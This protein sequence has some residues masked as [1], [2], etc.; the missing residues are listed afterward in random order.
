M[1]SPL[2][3]VTALPEM[4]LSSRAVMQVLRA[5]EVAHMLL[6]PAS[7]LPRPLRADLIAHAS[8]SH[9]KPASGGNIMR[10]RYLALAM[11]WA[12]LA[13][14]LVSRAHASDEQDCNAVTV[15]SLHHCVQHAFEMGHISNAGVA[16]SLLRK[17]D[18]AIAAEDL[19]NTSLAARILEAFINEVEAQAGIHIDS[20]HADHM[21][22]HATNVIV[23][24]LSPP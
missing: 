12:V 8:G 10:A 21:V 11:V 13:V 15:I 9:A 17:I 6:E 5:R 16:N 14:A 22:T 4:W 19:G 23:D 7:H 18:A 3:N 20:T 24:L 1:M 2:S